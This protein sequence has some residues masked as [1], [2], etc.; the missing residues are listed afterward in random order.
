[1][2]SLSLSLSMY[3]YCRVSHGCIVQGPVQE[4]GNYNS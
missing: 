4:S 2:L 3:I 1:M